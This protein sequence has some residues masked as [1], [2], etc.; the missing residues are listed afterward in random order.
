[1]T[2]TS[3]K[4][5]SDE[6]RS[7]TRTWIMKYTAPKHTSVKRTSWIKHTQM[8]RESPEPA[9]EPACRVTHAS[10]LLIVAMLPPHLPALP[11]Q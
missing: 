3:A 11:H 10:L 6:A 4:H 7:T 1:M 5:T 9:M 8:I 2:D